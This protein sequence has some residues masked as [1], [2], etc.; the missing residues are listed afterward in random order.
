VNSQEHA[1][2]VGGSLGCEGDEDDGRSMLVLWEVGRDMLVMCTVDN[3]RH[4]SG[5]KG[6]QGHGDGVRG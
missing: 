5:L 6:N 3:S 2:S 1:G 4:A